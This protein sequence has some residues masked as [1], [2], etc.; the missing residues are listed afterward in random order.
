MAGNPPDFQSKPLNQKNS[1][2]DQLTKLAQ[3]G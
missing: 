1:A 3:A 2:P